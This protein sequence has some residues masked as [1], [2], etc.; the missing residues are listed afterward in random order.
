MQS[1]QSIRLRNFLQKL[2][3]IAQ[4]GSVAACFFFPLIQF[5]SSEKKLDIQ[6]NLEK[7]VPNRKL[8][9]PHF[10]FLQKAAGLPA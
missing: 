3:A 2:L 7:P 6:A 4:N 5:I 9:H 1:V 10:Q 8:N